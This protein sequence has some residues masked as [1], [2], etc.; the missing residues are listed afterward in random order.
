MPVVDFCPCGALWLGPVDTKHGLMYPNKR[1]GW[2]F[3]LPRDGTD[4]EAALQQEARAKWRESHPDAD[5]SPGS[6]LRSVMAGTDALGDIGRIRVSQ[7]A[8]AVRA[9]D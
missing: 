6:L 1:Y 8:H 9:E 7:A 4:E 2:L 3:V 5:E